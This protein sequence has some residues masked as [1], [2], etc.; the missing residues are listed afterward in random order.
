[1]RRPLSIPIGS[2]SPAALVIENRK[3]PALEH[4]E[5]IDAQAQLLAREAKAHSVLGVPY[6]KRLAPALDLEE[7]A[8]QPRGAAAFP[9]QRRAGNRVLAGRGELGYRVL[10]AAADQLLESLRSERKQR[11]RVLEPIPE[12]LQ[13]PMQELSPR[14]GRDAR[15]RHTELL[16][17]QA[18]LRVSTKRTLVLQLEAAR[19]RRQRLLRAPCRTDIILPLR[20]QPRT[21]QP[22]RKPYRRACLGE[23]WRGGPPLLEQRARQ[24]LD[25]L[26]A[27][28]GAEHQLRRRRAPG[29]DERPR[30]LQP[31]RGRGGGPPGCDLRGQGQKRIGRDRRR[32]AIRIE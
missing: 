16:T 31:A 5:A 8:D 22:R 2:D 30:F 20:Q 11:A 24:Q 18:Q 3:T 19:S 14:I 4:I 21:M 32:K 28:G 10:Q 17:P 1:M 29:H 27:R 6:A 26:R 25:V 15:L 13:R 9:R 7:L 23:R 12:L